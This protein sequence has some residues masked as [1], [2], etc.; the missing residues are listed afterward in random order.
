MGEL[1]SLLVGRELS[2]VCMVRDHVELHFDGPVVRALTNPRGRFGGW[3][4]Q[5]PERDAPSAMRR[6]IGREVTGVELVGGVHLKLS[7]GPEHISIPLD[8]DAR[9][10][11][12]ALNVVGVDD[13]G[14]TDTSHLW[15]F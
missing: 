1:E 13:R 15:V 7:F 6:Y 10:G 11:P 2:A 8:D 12:E 14:V 4:W 3:G 5:F 9:S